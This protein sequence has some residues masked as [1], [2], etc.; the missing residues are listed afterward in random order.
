MEVSSTDLNQH[1]V[2][3]IRDSAFSILDYEQAKRQ[4]T[5]LY[6]KYDLT[7]VL[8]HWKR[9]DELRITLQ[10]LIR[11][12]LFK[13]I[14]VWNNNPQMNLTLQH[15]TNHS[16]THTTPIRI[17]NSKENLK[18]EAKYQACA[19]AKT[20]ACFYV[21]DDFNVDHYLK[22]LIS[23]FRSDPN[24]LHAITDPYTFY[25]NLVWSYFDAT[26]DLH[27]GFSWIGAGSIFLRQHAE[28]HLQLMHKYLRN[29]T[30]YPF[31]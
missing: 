10:Y 19:Q 23:S 13:E 1:S 17:I 20:R 15:L 14:I 18:D 6:N 9:F 7:A 27:T 22:C 31:L 2:S 3:K 11:T 5:V 8:L 26:I 24:L 12:N 4:E 25:T 29:R 21:D 16:Q 30:G 28:H